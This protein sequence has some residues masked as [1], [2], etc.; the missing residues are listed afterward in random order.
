M[1]MKYKPTNKQYP[2]RN[3]KLIMNVEQE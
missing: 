1:A 2:T 3:S